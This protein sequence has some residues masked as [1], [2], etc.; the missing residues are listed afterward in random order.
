MPSNSG[1]SVPV[2]KPNDPDRDTLFGQNSVSPLVGE[3]AKSTDGT[4]K[5]EVHETTIQS[6]Y[7]RGEA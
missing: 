2:A 7:E 3:L 1:C 6:C 5:W 4:N